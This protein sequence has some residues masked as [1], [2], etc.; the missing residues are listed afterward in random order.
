MEEYTNSPELD[1]EMD[2]DL[3]ADEPEQTSEDAPKTEEPE[4]ETQEAAKEPE[5]EPAKEPAK[6]KIRGKYNGKEI[7][8]DH[9]EVVA[10]AQKGMN[11]DKVHAELE[12]VKNSTGMKV[13]SEYAKESGYASTDEYI[14]DMEHHLGRVAIQRELTAI[15][16]KTPDIPDDVA[17]E[18]AESRVS[19]KRS[20]MQLEESKQKALSEQE[21]LK[22]W[23]DY[24]VKF[25]DVPQ[26][27]VEVIE[28]VRGGMSPVEAMLDWQ[29]EQKRQRDKR[30]QDEARSA[31]KN[32]QNKDKSVGSVA[33]STSAAKVDAFIMGLNG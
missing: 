29:R 13:L 20:K 17:N 18:L 8:W 31:R 7:E 1:F 14:A 15:K 30:A 27:P 12:K 5:K 3:F 21:K 10:L 28:R 19:A 23:L 16:S 6:E 25:P 4:Q 9:D 22:P 33:S 11:Y 26:P 2:G 32:K 24:N